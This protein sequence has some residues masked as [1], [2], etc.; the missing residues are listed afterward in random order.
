[1]HLSAAEGHDKVIEFLLRSKA[2]PN[3][4]DRW[5]GTPLQDALKSAHAGA[6][7]LL[8]AKGACVPKDFGVNAVCTAASEGN[9]LRMRM[10]HEFGMS[11]SDG[12]YDDRYPLHR[13]RH[14]LLRV[15]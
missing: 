13:G 7:T 10:L 12:D 5:M 2:N 3:C 1:L 15:S 8:Q 11:V 6:A 14:V 4:A 9:V